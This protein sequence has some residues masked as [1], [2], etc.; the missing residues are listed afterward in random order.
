[1]FFFRSKKED[2]FKKLKMA[3]LQQRLREVLMECS[4]LEAFD[5]VENDRIVHLTFLFSTFQMSYCVN[6]QSYL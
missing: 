4:V 2:F 5:S 1:M 3:S 6:L